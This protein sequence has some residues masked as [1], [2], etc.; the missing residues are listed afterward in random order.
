MTLTGVTL[1]DTS[2]PGMILTGTPVPSMSPNDVNTTNYTATYVLT[3][4][5]VDAG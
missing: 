5:D 4:A 3:Q 1:T 2:L